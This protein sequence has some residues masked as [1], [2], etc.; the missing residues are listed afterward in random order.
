MCCDDGRFHF[1][2][3]ALAEFHFR[4]LGA[5]LNGKER[6]ADFHVIATFDENLFDRSTCFGNDR[7]RAVGDQ[8]RI[9]FGVVV[10][11][12]KKDDQGQN[13]PKE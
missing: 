13:E 12:R 6:I 11:D 4:K 8:T 2:H 7:N 3:L 10:E 9:G 5:V 1:L